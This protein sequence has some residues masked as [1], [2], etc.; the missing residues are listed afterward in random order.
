MPLIQA[1][2]VK[3]N[4]VEYGKGDNIIVFLHGNLGCVNW[5]DLVWP[6]LPDD[7]HVY[8]FDWRG[9][10]DSEKPEPTEDY[11]NYSMEQHADDIISA[12]KA[13]GI[14]K[15]HLA[16]H[17]TGGIIC[18]Y[19]LLKE[20]AMFDKVFCLD[21]VG[22]MGLD[23]EA[24]YDLFPAMKASRDMTWAVVATAVPTLFEP[25]SLQPGNV[26][27]FAAA[28]TEE[29][30]QLFDLLVDKTAGLSDGIWIGTPF[31]L[32]KEYRSGALRARQ[33]EIQ[34]PHLVLWGDQDLWI[35]RADMEE[36]ARE[37]PNCELRVLEGVGHS[38][39]L[40]D[41]DLLAEQFKEYFA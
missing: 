37:M 40:E 36:M 13:L 8:A 35:A 9:C 6:R 5:M 12:I 25:D 2:E 21:P 24:N 1:G 32:T 38:C 30:K 22:P 4:Y 31:N 41:P 23:M 3:L 28:T 33:G 16:N 17:S 20:P 27:Q 10:G 15:C 11:A 39:N 7:L 29:Q 26:P 14:K 19:M 34:Q 18:S